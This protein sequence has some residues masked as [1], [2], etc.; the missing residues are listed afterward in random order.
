[1]ESDR[2]TNDKQQELKLIPNGGIM[3]LANLE[4]QGP[5][6][7]SRKDK[8]QQVYDPVVDKKDFSNYSNSFPFVS[9]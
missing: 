3:Q 5:L 6:Q 1:M 4:K 9:I 7:E 2:E 8:K